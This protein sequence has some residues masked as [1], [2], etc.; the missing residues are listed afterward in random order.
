[1]LRWGDGSPKKNTNIFAG[2]L[3]RE[4]KPC[5]RVGTIR[6]IWNPMGCRGVW[7]RGGSVKKGFCRGIRHADLTRVG[8]DLTRKG[9]GRSKLRKL[10]RYRHKGE[11]GRGVHGMLCRPSRRYIK[12]FV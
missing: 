10:K 5:C 8:E 3:G 4:R 11:W 12:V 7:G 6:R 2:Y 9:E 1:M